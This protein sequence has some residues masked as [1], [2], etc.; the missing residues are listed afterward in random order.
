MVYDIQSHKCN[1]EL[2]IQIYFELRYR[3][4]D[5]TFNKYMVTNFRN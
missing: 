4:G 1:F 2:E 3:T 5:T